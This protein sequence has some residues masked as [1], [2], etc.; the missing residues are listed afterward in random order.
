MLTKIRIFINSLT[1]Q[2]ND[3]NNEI[4]LQ[5]ACA[6]LLAEVMR[7]DDNYQQSERNEITKQLSKHFSLSEQELLELLQHAE[8]LSE[9]ATDFYQ[10]TSQINKSYSIDDKIKII[11]MLWHVANAD[12]EISAIEQHIIRKVA[13]L[14]HLRHNEYLRSKLKITEQAQKK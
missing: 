14:L 12:G 3:I 6:V 10:F 11:E 8:Q 1:P 13:D 9:H 4:S 5:L 2:D 7:A